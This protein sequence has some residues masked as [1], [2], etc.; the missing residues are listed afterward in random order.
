MVLTNVTIAED[1][2]KES[3]EKRTDMIQ[4][5]VLAKT[6]SEIAREKFPDCIM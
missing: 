5:S 2:I 3:S 4:M 6:V 1:W